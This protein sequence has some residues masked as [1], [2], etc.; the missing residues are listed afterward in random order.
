MTK[1]NTDK[2]I[3]KDVE[4][5]EGYY[6]VSN[7][8]L[9]RSKDRISFSGHKLKG[10]VLKQTVNKGYHQIG[11]YKDDER[12]CET[13]SRLVAKAFIPNP[14]NKPEVN[15]IDEN[16]SNNHVDNLEWVTAKENANHGTRPDRL[17]KI[18]IKNKSHKHFFKN[19]SSKA[20][21]RQEDVETGKVMNEFPSV[22]E[23]IKSLGNKKTS[24]NISAC[25]SGRRKTA[26][27]FKWERA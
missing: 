25:L 22:T 11:L 23:A 27:G 3:W 18:G 5:Y 26:Y 15:H 19:G 10:R 16:K 4:G 1:H 14:E 6:Q 12:F 7:Y 9:V 13:V 2:E 24:S 20:P 17:R 8:G 21:V